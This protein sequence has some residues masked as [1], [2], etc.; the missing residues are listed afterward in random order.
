MATEKKTVF[1]CLRY[2]RQSATKMQSRITIRNTEDKT[3]KLLIANNKEN[4]GFKSYQVEDE[5]LTHTR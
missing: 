5:N 3:Q 1:D 2:C 4:K